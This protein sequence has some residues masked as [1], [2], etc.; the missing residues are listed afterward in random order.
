MSR[1]SYSELIKLKTFDERFE[2]LQ[3]GSK[4]GDETF[5]ASRYVNQKLYSSDEWRKFRNRVIIRDKGCDLGCE[6]RP[7]DGNIRTSDIHIHHINPI[8]EEDIVLRNPCVFDMDN[9]ICVSSNTH[10]AIHYGRK[11]TLIE[12]YRERTAGDTNLWTKVF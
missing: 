11:T 7:I 1:K 9:V 4:I 2:Y 6:E 10:K 12:P 5:G 3:T 8:A